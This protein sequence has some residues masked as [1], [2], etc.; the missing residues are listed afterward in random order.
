MMRFHPEGT[1]PSGRNVA[2]DRRFSALFT[3]LRQG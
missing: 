2:P 1:L 3:S